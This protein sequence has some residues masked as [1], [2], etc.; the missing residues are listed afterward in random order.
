[1]RTLCVVILA[2]LIVTVTSRVPRYPAEMR[3][4]MF[5]NGS[6]DNDNEND[7]DDDNNMIIIIVCY[8]GGCD[9]VTLLQLKGV[10]LMNGNI[11]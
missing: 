8:D 11:F 10:S 4:G 6:N 2:V 3:K 7:N 9:D 5:N 1:M